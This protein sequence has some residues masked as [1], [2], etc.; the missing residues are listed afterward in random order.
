MSLKNATP[1][2]YIELPNG[3]KPIFI[4]NDIFLNHVF[5]NAENWEALRTIINIIIYAYREIYHD[6]T[7]MPIIGEFEVQTQYRYLLSDGKTTRDQDI[8]ATEDKA[9]IT[10]VEFQIRSATNP[11]IAIRSVEYFGLGI[12]NNKGYPAN[13]LWLLAEDVEELLAGEVFARYVLKNERTNY[14]HP[15]TSGIIYVSL[16]KLSKEDSTAGELAAYLL[17]KITD[18][19]DKQVK[20]VKAAIDKGFANFKTDKDVVTVMS[21]QDRWYGEGKADGKTEGITKGADRLAELIKSGLPVDEALRIV[22][23]EAVEKAAAS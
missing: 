22:K 5:E 15:E 18:P 23:E 8:K 14:P 1:L 4:M 7:L 19:Q 3:A 2:G 21:L 10:Y 16:E 6:T 9:A 17:G 13:Q 20:A 12:G 11:S